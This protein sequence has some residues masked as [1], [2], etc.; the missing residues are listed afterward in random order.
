MG[1]TTTSTSTSTTTSTTTETTPYMIGFTP[2]SSNTSNTSNTMTCDC[3]CNCPNLGEDCD[4]NCGC[5]MQA[6]GPYMG[7]GCA[8][9]YTRICPRRG[10]LCPEDMIGKLAIQNHVF[11]TEMSLRETKAAL[12]QSKTTKKIRL[13]GTTFSCQIVLKHTYSEVK[14]GQSSIKCSPSSPRDQTAKQ[15][16]FSVNGYTFKMNAEINPTKFLSVRITG[17]PK[18]T[19]TTTSTTSTTTTSTPT[20]STTTT[21]TTTTLF[22]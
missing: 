11:S 21:T 14:L 16:E 20:T 17:A 4:C 15:V 3:N 5:P 13:S 18:T 8:P 1:S 19:T 6:T 12:I 2:T 22:N 9:G 10:L 7:D